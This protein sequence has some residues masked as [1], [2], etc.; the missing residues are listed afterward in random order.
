MPGRARGGYSGQSAQVKAKPAPRAGSRRRSAGTSRAKPAGIPPDAEALLRRAEE[1][2][3]TLCKADICELKA[4][5][6]PP[7][8]VKTVLAAVQTVLGLPTEWIDCKKS[9]ADPGG[10]LANLV[11][12]EKDK[13]TRKRLSEIAK[14]TKLPEF[15]VDSVKK[16]SCAAAG[17][18][19]WVIAIH[20]YGKL[21]NELQHSQ[22]EERAAEEGPMAELIRHD[23]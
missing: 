20:D 23:S 1:G 13:L 21:R 14:F 10:F 8:M 15:N 4:F 12:F 3:K 6:S 7:A 5:A 19:S 11:S 17:L 18:C 16:Q 9:M 22:K 2:L